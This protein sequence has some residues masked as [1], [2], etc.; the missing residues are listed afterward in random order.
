MG[1]HI[2]IQKLSEQMGLTSRTLRHWE[3]EGLFESY[4]DPV[5]GWRS[6]DSHS[7]F[8]VRLTA[9]LR[10]YDIALKDIK[11]ILDSGSC[12]T[13][14]AVIRR[15]LHV[16]NDQ[17]RLNESAEISLKVLLTNLTSL[18]SERLNEANLEQILS[19]MPAESGGDQKKEDPPMMDTN[20]ANLHVRFVTLPPMRAAYYIAVS[21]SPEDE[22]LSTVLGFLKAQNLMGTA[23]IFGGDMPPLPSGEGIP[24]GFGVLASIPK[25]IDVTAPLKEMNVP[26]GLYAAFESTDDIGGS[27]KKLMQ[28]LSDHEEYTFDRSRQC[29]EE[30]I[31][32][33]AP[34]GSGHEYFI[35]L[36][37]PVKRK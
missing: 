32:N 18:K 22:A 19:T 23:R 33:D 30:H 12:Q 11:K 7:V 10:S 21:I 26:G 34:E 13:L 17:K 29:F 2:A 27:W 28:Y 31:R 16:L 35:N 4:R 1:Q 5:S 15:Y 25:D 36:L 8:C 6:Y 3:S 14:C 9:L 37:E 20:T 24:Y